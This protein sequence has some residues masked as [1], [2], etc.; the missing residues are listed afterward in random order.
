VAAGLAA[1]PMLVAGTLGQLVDLLGG[2]GLLFVFAAILRRR[3]FV[4]A[5]LFTL[6]IEYVVV[7]ATGRAGSGSVIAYAVGLVVLSELLLFAGELPRAARVDSAVAVEALLVLGGIA[8]AGALL[9]LV[10]LAAMTVRIPG[11][12]EAAL[13]GA[14]AAVALLALPVLLL[15]RSET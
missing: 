6:A 8:L 10:T 11:D 2:V 4:G 12:F 1:Y 14:S 15:R 5:A 13:L 9:A 3:H 7:E